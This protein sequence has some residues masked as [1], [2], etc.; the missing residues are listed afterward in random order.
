M[1]N[2]DE[3]GDP[4]PRASNRGLWIGL[5][6]LG[7]LAVLGLAGC[8]VVAGLG[9]FQAKAVVDA[10]EDRHAALAGAQAF[11]GNL[12]TD[13]IDAAYAMTSTGFRATHTREQFD[14]FL[15][16]HPILTGWETRSV[17]GPTDETGDPPPR[18]VVVRIRLHARRSGVPPPVPA[19][20][21]WAFT[22]VNEAG[23]WN[24]DQFVPQ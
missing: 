5:G 22:L 7:G 10:N 6:I 2:L 16:D 9:L 3:Y 23:L 20:E 12:Q 11:L 13:R 21:T 4:R 14:R 15:A 19:D 1:S 18:R 17:G 8:V 24:V